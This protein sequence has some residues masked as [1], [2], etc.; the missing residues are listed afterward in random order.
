MQES[1]A[2]PTDNSA[3]PQGTV[4]SILRKKPWMPAARVTLFVSLYLA[5]F[6]LVSELLLHD[7]KHVPF[8]SESWVVLHTV[9]AESDRP[10]RIF[11]H[12]EFALPGGGDDYRQLYMYTMAKLFSRYGIESEPYQRFFIALHQVNCLLLFLFVVLVTRSLILG[13]AAS[14]LFLFHPATVEAIAWVV[15]GRNVMIC[16][17]GM[18]M[19]LCATQ[20][21]R[22]GKMGW[23]AIG[24]SSL[25][26]LAACMTQQNGV[27]LPLAYGAVFLVHKPRD[28]FWWRRGL[29]TAAC[30]LCVFVAFAVFIGLLKIHFAFVVPDKASLAFKY[31]RL[32][33]WTFLPF[34]V[35]AKRPYQVAGL[36]LFFGLTLAI[37]RKK[38]M[39]GL[40]LTVTVLLMIAPLAYFYIAV[41]TLYFNSAIG[42]VVWGMLLADWPKQKRPKATALLLLATLSG[43]SLYQHRKIQAKWVIGGRITRQ[44]MDLL[45]SRYPNLGTENSVYLIGTHTITTWFSQTMVQCFL[46]CLYGAENPP[47]G[48]YEPCREDYRFFCGLPE[49]TRRDPRN[50]FLCV[51]D[52][53]LLDVTREVRE[54]PNLYFYYPSI[55]GENTKFLGET[56]LFSTATA[57]VTFPARAAPADKKVWIVVRMRGGPAAGE[58]PVSEVV[59]DGHSLGQ[60][61]VG[62]KGPF[63]S[64]TAAERRE[65]IFPAV[66]TDQALIAS[67][68]AF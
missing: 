55:R 33:V 58:D 20:A 23:A 66:L 37:M 67:R 68:Y 7:L 40:L 43:I 22:P 2:G 4:M 8:S 48:F 44:A 3:E 12:G 52:G 34:L 47:K 56:I 1:V 30:F 41:R 10:W 64:T 46:S 62:G 53:S 28:R 42:C 51:K 59:L 60:R 61:V 39:A 13:M 9:R 21:L 32:V 57:F 63:S 5:C 26:Y 31:V 6:L 54:E 29:A 36:L 49:E 15:A 11:F 65:Y 25:A 14:F 17:F 24:I 45:A 50:C 38:N 18:I 35:S 19:M 27:A 16:F